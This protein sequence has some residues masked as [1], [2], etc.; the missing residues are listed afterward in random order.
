M[1]K[2]KDLSIKLNV[3]EMDLTWKLDDD[4][5]TEKFFSDFAKDETIKKM[6]EWIDE[7]LQ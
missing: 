3:N 5:T 1:L 6:I 4:D 7:N 2:G